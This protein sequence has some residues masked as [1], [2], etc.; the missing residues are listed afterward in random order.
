MNN[1]TCDTTPDEEHFFFIDTSNPK[2]GYA[3]LTEETRGNYILRW[4]IVDSKRIQI[5]LEDGELDPPELTPYY[6]YKIDE[7]G[8][9][10]SS[11]RDN[12][13]KAILSTISFDPEYLDTKLRNQLTRIIVRLH[14]EYSNT[15]PRLHDS[16]RKVDYQIEKIDKA[17]ELLKSP[18]LLEQLIEIIGEQLAGERENIAF[19]SVSLIQCLTPKYVQIVLFA[20][21]ATG[22]SHLA[23]SVLN[24]FPEYMVYTGFEVSPT[25]LRNA[26]EK[27]LFDDVRIFYLTQRDGAGS[28][29]RYQLKMM[30]SRDNDGNI[31]AVI[32]DPDSGDIKEMKLKPMGLISTHI[33]PDIIDSE[34]ETR[35]VQVHLDESPEQTE[36]VLDY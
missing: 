24:I 35:N 13:H 18:D 14:R 3:K 27:G 29:S 34:E 36:K 28:K 8:N 20:R 12:L 10:L 21:S 32:T 19:I 6:L 22:K 26:S 5:C 25:A 7:L 30:S 23:R 16:R 9:K 4:K 11:R 1:H 33:N 2:T 31:K 15:V 17:V